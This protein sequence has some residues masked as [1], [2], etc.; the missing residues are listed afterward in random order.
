[1]M[2]RVLFPLMITVVATAGLMTACSE[3]GADTPEPIPELAV[4][5]H[6]SITID[7]AADW[8]S[9][10]VKARSED[11]PVMVVFYADWCIWCKRLDST[12]L[13]DTGVATF[14]TD[15]VVAIRLD[16]DNDG[17]ALS[18]QHRVEGPPTIILFSP[19]GTEIG[20]IPGYLPPDGFLSRVQTI[21]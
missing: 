6:G 3:K 16:V 17:K 10:F 19:E 8:N 13:A 18:R 15:Q 20:R 1:M 4:S 21:L 11:K 12:T 7:W 14:V 2:R 5:T 9:A